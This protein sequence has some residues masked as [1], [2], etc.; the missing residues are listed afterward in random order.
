MKVKYTY[1]KGCYQLFGVRFLFFSHAWT[2]LFLM[3]FWFTTGA[4][5][6]KDNTK[7]LDI[8][9]QKNKKHNEVVPAKSQNIR[10]VCLGWF[11]KPVLNWLDGGHR[12][13]SILINLVF[14][15][16]YHHQFLGA[17]LAAPVGNAECPSYPEEPWRRDFPGGLACGMFS[18][19]AE[20]RAHMRR[21]LCHFSLA[22]TWWK[23]Q[24]PS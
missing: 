17:A 18:L 10:T 21:R 15:K 4:L 20:A 2:I 13:V 16:D 1:E 22:N 5:Q 8:L 9:R 12:N 11:T 3:W 6:R 7:C 24:L 23:R 19:P 14:V